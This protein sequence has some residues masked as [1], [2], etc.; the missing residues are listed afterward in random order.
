MLITILFCGFLCFGQ[1]VS[2][3]PYGINVHVQTDAVLQKAIDAGIKWVRV[4]AVWRDIEVTPGTFHWSN[5]DRV[6]NYVTS[7][8]VSVLVGFGTTP[9][10]ANGG[11]GGNYS[12]DNVAYWQRFVQATVRRYKSRVKCWAIWN[13]PNLQHFNAES[14]ERFLD[15]IFNPGADAVKAEDPSAFVVGPDLAHLT[16]TGVEWYFWLKYILSNT[17][18]RIDVISHHIYDKRGASYIYRSLE[19]GDI[20]I[21]SVK[22][23]IEDAGCSQKPFWITETGWNTYDYSEQSQGEK[24]LAMLKSMKKKQYPDKIFFYEIADDLNNGNPPWGIIKTDLTEKP[25]Y[26]IYKDFIAGKYDDQLDDGDDDKDDKKCPVKK[27]AQHMPEEQKNLFVGSLYNFRD[28]MVAL[29]PSAAALTHLYYAHADE[30]ENLRNQDSRVR[31]LSDRIFSSVSHQ[32][33]AAIFGSE[34][35]TPAS[36]AMIADTEQLIQCM[37]ENKLSTELQEVINWSEKEFPVMK[38]MKPGNYLINQLP[39]SI[40][41][42]N[43]VLVKYR[44]K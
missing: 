18:D 25:A 34:E 12:A 3:S 16:S 9:S 19:D 38:K 22:K 29:S 5:M 26:T 8:G 44:K 27:S 15:R 37:K 13:E 32:G 40:K 20:L 42:L 35:E 4:D 39:A 43:S 7:R 14:K 10:W 30:F 36:K 17:K 28:E 1:Q 33:F 24:Y 23:I 41:K 31:K 21:P 11:K 6:I 2:P